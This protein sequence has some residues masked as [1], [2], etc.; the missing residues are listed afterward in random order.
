EGAEGH[1]ADLGHARADGRAEHHEV[2]RGGQHRRQDALHHGAESARHLELVDGADC[3]P[4]HAAPF[5]VDTKMSSSE[6]CCVSRSRN[7]MPQALTSRS[8]C[9][10]RARSCSLLKVNT[11]VRPSSDSV[12]CQDA[13]CGG[14]AASF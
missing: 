14:M 10:M 2:K 12:S 4:V 9:A 7:S 6:L 13:S 8:S 3:M 1:P 11:S 5:S